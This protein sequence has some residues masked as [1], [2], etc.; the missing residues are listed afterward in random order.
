MKGSGV[1]EFPYTTVTGKIST[2]FEKIKQVGQ[3]DKVTLTWLKSVGFT[4]TNDRSLVALLKFVDFLDDS[5]SPTA[6]WLD[7][8]GANGEQVLAEGI[9][10]GYSELFTIY[11]NAFSQSDQDLQSFFSTRTKAGKQVVDKTVTTFKNL[12]K[13]AD[14][15]TPRPRSKIQ[16][17]VT[18]RTQELAAGSTTVGQTPVSINI[19]LELPL[20]DAETY[21]AFFAAMKKHLLS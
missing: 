19:K 11:P 16:S 12:C 8:R 21:E 6:R 15:Q 1:A 3:P 5:G 18:K 7:Y 17:N 4:S 10:Q 14:F 13:I 9:R 20:A 2:L